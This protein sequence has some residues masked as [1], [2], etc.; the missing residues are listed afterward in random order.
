QSDSTVLFLVDKFR[1]SDYFAILDDA[2]PELAGRTTAPRSGEGFQFEQ[3]PRLRQ[4]VSMKDVAGPGMVTWSSFLRGAE[5]VPESSLRER[6]TQLGP[7]DPINVQ[8]T[9]GTTGFPKGAT[10]SHRNILMNAWCI[11][12]CQ[13][14]TEQ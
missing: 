14:L 8:Y 3:L 7:D 10:L 11:G 4:I 2:I 6:E 12:D 5:S 9:S 1:K 13:K